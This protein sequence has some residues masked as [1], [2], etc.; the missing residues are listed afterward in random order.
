[1]KWSHIRVGQE[2]GV[3]GQLVLR[4]LLAE[5]DDVE[6]CT[7]YNMHEVGRE[8]LRGAKKLK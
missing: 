3:R 5:D 7:G 4:S 8:T 1:M 6:R 2:G